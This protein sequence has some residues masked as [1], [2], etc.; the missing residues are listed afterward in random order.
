MGPGSH[1]VYRAPYNPWAFTE[2]FISKFMF[3]NNLK[4]GVKLS[5]F[6]KDFI[7]ILWASR[8]ISSLRPRPEDFLYFC[9]DLWVLNKKKDCFN[10]LVTLNT[11]AL[12][13]EALEMP[14]GRSADDTPG[15]HTWGPHSPFPHLS[16]FWPWSQQPF[17][18]LNM[19]WG[20]NISPSWAPLL[21]LWLPEFSFCLM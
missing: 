6:I 1:I 2:Y 15:S 12:F 17:L 9:G 13:P 7:F 19:P 21:S 18:H 11:S 14:A 16:P 5:F 8:G 10:A 4:P 20:G 3:R